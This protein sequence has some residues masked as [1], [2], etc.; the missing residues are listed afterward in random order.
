MKGKEVFFQNQRLH[1]TFC[2]SE[3][4]EK[5]AAGVASI[6]IAGDNRKKYAQDF[7][8]DKK[9]M[10]KLFDYLL[11]R[12]PNFMPSETVEKNSDSEDD[13]VIANYKK[14]NKIPKAHVCSYKKK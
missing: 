6:T 5:N 11:D 9:V 8:G 14:V 13:I 10:D 7:V 1:F 3:M 4:A 2:C 12:H